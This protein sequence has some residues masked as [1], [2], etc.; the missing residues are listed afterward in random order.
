MSL[1][2]TLT[3]LYQR[4][5]AVRIPSVATVP[6]V[7]GGGR[8]G[9]GTTPKKAPVKTFAAA[10]A[11]DPYSAFLQSDPYDPAKIN[12]LAQSGYNADAALAAK[13]ASAGYLTSDQID[14]QAQN[15]IGQENALSTS[16]AQRLGMIQQAS[17]GTGNATGAALLGQDTAAQQAANRSI[18]AAGGTPSAP[19]V[20]TGL[21]A[22][23]GSQTSAEGNLYG[24]L[25]A[26]ALEQG[27]VQS[28]KALDAAQTTKT[29]NAADE[30]KTLSGFLASLASPSS[31][32]VT[33]TSAD[34]AVDSS[35][36]ATDLSIWSNLATQKE[37]ATA[38]GD[39]VG[40]AAAAN[41][42][43]NLEATMANSTKR[44]LGLAADTTKTTVATTNAGARVESA[45]VAAAER[46]A[47]ASITAK[48]KQAGAAN[49]LTPSQSLSLGKSIVGIRT[50][51][52]G[53]TVKTPTAYTVK[54]QKPIPT[55]NGVALPG[56][57][58]PTAETRPVPVVDY[59]SGA[60]LKP[61]YFGAGIKVSGKAVPTGTT[62]SKTINNSSEW[63]K[64][65]E[66]LGLVMTQTKLPRT[67]AVRYLGSLGWP[68]PK[69]GGK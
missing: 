43:K 30:Q 58:P 13:N 17:V 50:Q 15:R 38:E 19:S 36:R 7:A 4:P 65:K 24:G 18:I 10:A 62:A 28:Q 37:Q 9:P 21:G 42:E 57:K 45:K 16:L 51:K 56:A 53:T 32:A 26:A 8:T 33:M 20:P 5:P 25:G 39:K 40:E 27:N 22:V 44:A 1:S 35:N 6:S 46:K 63:T 48:A 34:T 54:V 66:A 31:R 55:V 11:T 69:S 47:V 2:N 41:A 49:G 23:L 59:D 12:Q 29:T 67:Q 52:S 68:A 60:Y 64:Y 14:A 61:G 3:T